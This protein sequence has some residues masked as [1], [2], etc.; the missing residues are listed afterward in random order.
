MCI[1][2]LSKHFYALPFHKFVIKPIV[3]TLVMGFFI[4][5]CGS[6][7]LFLLIILAII[8]YFTILYFIKGFSKEDINYFKQMF[9]GT[10]NV[11]KWNNLPLTNYSCRNP[12]N[13]LA[14]DV[15]K[16]IYWFMIL[17]QSNFLAS[18]KFLFEICFRNSGFL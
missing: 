8:L 16:S 7:N 4:Y 3:A 10:K 17:F 14:I 11:K 12:F 18:C 13:Y 6:I 15:Y 2:F 1:Y 9:M 5:F